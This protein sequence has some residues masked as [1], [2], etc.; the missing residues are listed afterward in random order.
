[1]RLFRPVRRRAPTKDDKDRLTGCDTR[2]ALGDRLGGRPRDA[3]LFFDLDDM[4]LMNKAYGYEAGDALLAQV[5]R[6]LRALAGEYTVARIGGDEFFVLLPETSLGEA[7]DLGAAIAARI[8]E[9]GAQW[10]FEGGNPGIGASVVACRWKND[11]QVT[12]QHADRWLAQVKDM[13][14]PSGSNVRGRGG[15]VALVADLEDQESLDRGGTSTDKTVIRF[16]NLD[17][18]QYFRTAADRLAGEEAYLVGV[19]AQ[20]LSLVNDRYGPRA[21][22]AALFALVARLR[23]LAPDLV[24]MPQARHLD[25][26]GDSFVM[27]VPEGGERAHELARAFEDAP[28]NVKVQQSRRSRRLPPRKENVQVQLRAAVYRLGDDLECS[29]TRLNRLV[30]GGSDERPLGPGRPLREYVERLEQWLLELEVPRTWE[31][32]AFLESPLGSTADR[33][34]VPGTEIDADAFEPRFNEIVT[35][36]ELCSIKLCVVGKAGDALICAVEWL[37]AKPGQGRPPDQVLVNFSALFPRGT[38]LRELTPSVTPGRLGIVDEALVS[39]DVETSG[40]VPGIYSLLAIG[41]CLVEDTGERFYAELKP[42]RERF[43]ARAVEVSW[44]GVPAEE[45]LARLAHEG[46]DP[47]AAMC[48]FRDWVLRVTAGAKPVYVAWGAAFD[49]AFTHYEFATSGIDDPFGYAP[50]DIKSYWAGKAGVSLEGTRKSRLPAWLFD[51]LGEHTHRA[52]ED[53]ARQA[54]VFSRMR[55]APTSTH[56]ASAPSSETTYEQPEHFHRF[57]KRD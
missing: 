24:A 54:E 39:V 32:V 9:I 16:P 41:A 7:F 38:T 44:P 50:L 18:E 4:R 14:E 43:D 15:C 8:T 40:P 46:H 25:I 57:S 20:R 31:R 45:T 48:S 19:D 12:I 29:L 37:P 35:S 55:A 30:H 51:G 27:L 13:R 10:A 36:T 17:T 34:W 56:V 1:M 47:T 6:E 3:F 53:A 22:D 11:P 52:D 5:G 26:G 2:A 42:V 33:E 21:G 28:L 49:W 23:E